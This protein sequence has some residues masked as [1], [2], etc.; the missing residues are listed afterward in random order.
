[1]YY[2]LDRS[3]GCSFLLTSNREQ[4]ILGQ[5]AKYV[6]EKEN[7]SRRSTIHDSIVRHEWGI[8][9]NF[10]FMEIFLVT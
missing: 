9:G 10:L 1:M 8:Q 5:L 6:V 7:D 2:S 4:E 3:P